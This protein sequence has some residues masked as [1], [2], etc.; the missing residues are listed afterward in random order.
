MAL[1]RCGS[2]VF[3][4]NG[5]SRIAGFSLGES[6]EPFIFDCPKET[7]SQAGPPDEER[8]GVVAFAF[9]PSGT[10][11]A[12]SMDSKQLLLFRA[13]PWECLS[14]RT[15]LRRSTSLAITGAEDRILLADKSGDVYSFSINHPDS[16]GQLQLGHLSMLL[17]VAVSP[18]DRY[19]IT[20][21][22]D[23]KI[24]VSSL[25]QPYIVEAYCLGHHEFVSQLSIPPNHPQLLVSGSGDGTIRLWQ[26]E[27]GSELHCLNLSELQS[28]RC[29]ENRCAV[30]RLAYCRGKDLF[31]VVCDSPSSVYVLELD[32][33]AERL[34]HQQTIT[35]KQRAWDVTFDDCGGLWLLDGDRAVL[36]Q[37]HEGL[38]QEIPDHPGQ[39]KINEVIHSNWP[40]FE[41]AGICTK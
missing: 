39:T 19:I 5:G 28:S 8:N 41:A 21:D 34:L 20:A 33:E 22:R 7:R 37:Q 1:G 32:V 9:S 15:A 40:V 16:P 6:G 36:Y 29:E 38:W 3:L 26:Y 17:A 27:K 12:V 14:V 2:L 4:G 31:A 23:E 13:R 11:V 30:V 25:K 35:V 10:Y 24:R 18:D